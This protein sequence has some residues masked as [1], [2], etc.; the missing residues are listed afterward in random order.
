[1]NVSVGNEY[2]HETVN[3]RDKFGLI[4]KPVLSDVVFLQT[5]VF[6]IIHSMLVSTESRDPCLTFIA[7][8]LQRNHR[9]AQIQ[10]S[11]HINYVAT[12]GFLMQEQ[13]TCMHIL[14]LRDSFDFKLNIFSNASL[15]LMLCTSKLSL[16]VHIHIILILKARKICLSEKMSQI[17]ILQI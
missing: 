10:V 12:K 14:V 6:K 8:V 13:L 2:L 5:E 7:T 4:V 17:I 11:Q 9:K 3:V 16:L 15:C 1:M